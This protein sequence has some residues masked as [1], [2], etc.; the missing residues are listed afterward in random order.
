MD[1]VCIIV[2]PSNPIKAL[3]SEQVRDIY[4]GKITNWKELGG[5]D[6]AIVVISRDTSSGTYETFEG[7]VMKGQ[8]MAS[9][10]ELVTTNPQ[11]SS[12]VESTRGAIGYVGFGFVSASVKAVPLDGVKPSVQT[13]LNGQYPVSRPLFMFTNGYPKPGSLT[14][15]FVTF[16][17]TE[18]GQ[19]IIKDKGFVA[20]TNY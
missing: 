6:T 4:I 11:M 20:F 3:T 14:Y 19:E 17:L 9:N 1:G 5:P 15:K 12:R 18:E 2:H 10:V 8:K 16:Y 13:I 7:F